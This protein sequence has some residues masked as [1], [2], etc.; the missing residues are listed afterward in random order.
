VNH[1]DYYNFHS[2]LRNQYVGHRSFLLIKLCHIALS[3]HRRK[4]LALRIASP[5]PGDESDPLF[6]AQG[7]N[8][9]SSNPQAAQESIPLKR[10]SCYDETA[11]CVKL[12][13]NFCWR[14]NEI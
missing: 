5:A 9:S 10:A 7:W 12:R 13:M 3:T 2:C 14:N 11:L 4:N 6:F 8:P 1:S